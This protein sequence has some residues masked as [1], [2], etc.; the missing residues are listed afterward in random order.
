MYRRYSV[1]NDLRKRHRE[2]MFI[3]KMVRNNITHDIQQSHRW[4]TGQVKYLMKI[5]NNHGLHRLTTLIIR[6]LIQNNAFDVPYR[7]CLGGVIKHGLQFRT[8][9]GLFKASL[10]RIDNSKP[11][12]L[13]KQKWSKNLRLIPLAMNHCTNIANIPNFLHTIQELQDIACTTLYT[14][15]S[16]LLMNHPYLRKVCQNLMYKDLQCRNDFASLSDLYDYIFQ[17]YQEQQGFCAVSGIKFNASMPV[18]CWISVDAINPCRHHTRNN[19]RLICRF[20]NSSNY[21]KLKK[22]NVAALSDPPTAWSFQLFAEYIGTR[23]IQ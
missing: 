2:F 12:F 17:I 21:D 8:H 14:S 23:P 22:K 13:P 6:D 19:M 10:D 18:Y 1:P 5:H 15:Q 16:D 9:G 11:H 20:L 3:K 7:D 4:T